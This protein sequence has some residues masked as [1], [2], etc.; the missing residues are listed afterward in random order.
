MLPDTN[1]KQ[2]VKLVVGILLMLIIL[3]PLLSV[4]KMSP[5]HL[6]DQIVLSESEPAVETNIENEINSKKNE[7]ERLQSAYVLEEV[8]VQMKNNVEE[9]L[10]KNYEA[11]IADMEVEWEKDSS[12]QVENLTSIVVLL[13]KAESESTENIEEVNIQIT[14]STLTTETVKSSEQSPELKAF[15]ANEW[16]VEESAIIIK[17]KEE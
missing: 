7:I 1:L 13:D 11:E 12:Q 6:V 8:V 14:D 5:D 17:W 3:E 15:L 9:E 4:F 16:G 2:Y 10:E